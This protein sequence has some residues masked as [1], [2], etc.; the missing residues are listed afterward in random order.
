M[1]PVFADRDHFIRSA[2]LAGTEQ[3]YAV[4]VN[5]EGEVL[6]RVGGA[7]D[8]DKASKLRETLLLSGL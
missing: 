7:F 1:A 3:V 8:A 2:G 4:M 5:R 6:A